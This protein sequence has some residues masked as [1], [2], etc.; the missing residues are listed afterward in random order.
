MPNRINGTGIV[1]P[2]NPR[3]A[4]SRGDKPNAIPAGIAPLNSISGSMDMIRTA[5]SAPKPPSIC[6]NQSNM[7]LPL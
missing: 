2:T 5:G 3:I 7:I 1:L 4:E 6:C